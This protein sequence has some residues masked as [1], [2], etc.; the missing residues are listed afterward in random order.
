V[1]EIFYQLNIHHESNNKI[2]NILANRVLTPKNK[3][4]IP[5]VKKKLSKKTVVKKK[6]TIKKNVKKRVVKKK[7]SKKKTK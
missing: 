5:L 3:I 7:V 2:K 1:T 6:A 4:I